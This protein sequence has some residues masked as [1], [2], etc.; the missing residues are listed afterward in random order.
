MIIVRVRESAGDP[1]AEDA[2]A[3]ASEEQD[4]PGVDLLEKVLLGNG[5]ELPEIDLVRQEPIVDLHFRF[6]GARERI[7]HRVIELLEF[8]DECL[9]RFEGSLHGRLFLKCEFQ[10]E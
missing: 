9:H 1:G 6:L 3:V 8:L 4:V 7:C 5:V 2:L 10:M